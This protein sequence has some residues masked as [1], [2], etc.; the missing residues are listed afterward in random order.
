[1]E[2]SSEDAALK[3]KL[4]SAILGR[5]DEGQHHWKWLSQ[6]CKNF[7][8]GEMERVMRQEREV[9]EEVLM[10]QI[11]YYYVSQKNET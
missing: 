9:R 3:G 1:M 11:Y 5:L 2:Q 7:L 4:A 8:Q 10:S 6:L